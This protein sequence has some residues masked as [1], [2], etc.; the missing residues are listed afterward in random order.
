MTDTQELAS[1]QQE[2]VQSSFSAHFCEQT[3]DANKSADRVRN[4]VVVVKD[5]LKQLEPKQSPQP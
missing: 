5:Q 1:T 2:E 3:A 4:F